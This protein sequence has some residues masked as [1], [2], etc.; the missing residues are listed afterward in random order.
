MDT[1]D[2][3]F[4][5]LLVPVVLYMYPSVSLA[6]PASR[7]W[8]CNGNRIFYHSIAKKLFSLRRCEYRLG[9]LRAPSTAGVLFSSHRIQ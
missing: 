3:S 7:L 8:F 4:V 2:L 9:S 1:D 6:R 5:T